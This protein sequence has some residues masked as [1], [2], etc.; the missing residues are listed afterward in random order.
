MV[1]K[2]DAVRGQAPRFL[3]PVWFALAILTMALLHLLLPHYR[4]LPDPAL[5]WAVAPMVLGG[6]LAAWAAMLF[7]AA[8]TPLRPSQIPSRMVSGGPY[9][10]TRNPMYLGL[11]LIL[12]GIWM[13]MG[14]PWTLVPVLAFAVVMDLQA[15]REEAA[16]EA[17]FG[18][19]YAAYR[20]RVR[21][22]I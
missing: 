2:P 6:V 18:E 8:D 19:E 5:Y 17:L 3:P 14:S 22:W 10:V 1:L 12:V 13:A 4:I 21:R 15:R 11:I 20:K 7:T 16:L 9:R